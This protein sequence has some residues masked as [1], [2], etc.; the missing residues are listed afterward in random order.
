MN[1]ATKAHEL[2]EVLS[3][4]GVN[5]VRLEDIKPEC[6]EDWSEDYAILG[7][8][9]PD[10]DKEFYNEFAAADFRWDLQNFIEKFFE[11]KA[12]IKIYPTCNEIEIM[13]KV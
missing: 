4:E 2:R 13:R 11:E 8:A 5:G 3:K 10:P 12:E 1:I 6:E 7:D 9:Y